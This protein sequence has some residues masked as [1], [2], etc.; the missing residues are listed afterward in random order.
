M[1]TS[2]VNDAVTLLLFDVETQKRNGVSGSNGGTTTSRFSNQCSN[3][4]V[5]T[6]HQSSTENLA[7]LKSDYLRNFWEHHLKSEY[8]LDQSKSD[9]KI[10]GAEKVINLFGRSALSLS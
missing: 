6:T 8:K 4:L 7:Q 10:G 9:Q 3:L 2:F 5:V 1:R